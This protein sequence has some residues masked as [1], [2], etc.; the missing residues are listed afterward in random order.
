MLDSI[1]SVARRHGLS[2]EGVAALEVAWFAALEAAREENGSTLTAGTG[3]WAL[4]S[5]SV[6][7]PSAPTSVAATQPSTAPGMRSALPARYADL[8]VL[9]RGGMGEVRRVRDLELN[10]TLAMKIAHA[11]F[12][13][14]PAALSRF[15][16]EAQATAQLQHP[17]IVPVHDLGRLP[18]GRFWF[19]MKEVRG[20][21]LTEA[22][23]DVHAVSRQG[24][25][26]APSGW[27][28]RRLVTAFHA[29]CHAVAYA[30]ARG[31]VH[32]D[33]KPDNVMLGVY[34][35]V[36][37]LDWGIAKLLGRPARPSDVEPALE[38]GDEAIETGRGARAETRV[39]QV[40]GTPA[41]MPPEQARGEVDRIDAR[42]DVYALG[43]ILYELLSGRPPYEGTPRAVLAQVLAGP[44]S[45]VGRAAPT[46]SLGLFEDLVDV[47][48]ASGPLLPEDLTSAC[49]RA[50]ARDPAERHATADALAHAV[51]DWLDG[52]R[53]RE[54]AL[55]VV[56]AACAKVPER[57]ALL[58][59]AMTLRGEA[60]ALLE[61]IEPWRPEDD[62]APG[63]VKED[64]AAELDR[65]AAQLDLD[66][67]HLLNAALTHAPEL[68]EAH[69]ALAQRYRAAHAAAEHARA[70]AQL[71]EVRLRRH[72]AS[73]PEAHPDR[74]GH[75]AY[76]Q[77]DGVLTLVTDPPGAE[78]R[79]FR[80]TLYHRRLVPTFERV[81]GVTPLRGVTLPMGSYL[82][83]VH[84]PERVAVRYPVVMGR[85]T[86]W[87]GVP[88]GGEAPLP[89]VLPLPSELGPDDVYIP[90]GWFWSG[91]EGQA[92][93]ALPRRRV[94]EDAFVMRRFPVTNREYLRFLDD[95]VAKGR[96]T[97]AL[98][99]APR[100]RPGSVGMDGA[101]IYG[102][103]GGRFFIQPDA[104]GD[105]WHPDD[106]VMMVAWSGAEAFAAWEA[107]RSGRPWC[108][109]REQAWE[110]AARGVDGRLY[111]WGDAFDPSW[112][113]TRVS[114]QGRMLPA[115]VD[116]FPVD[117]SV[118]GVR[119]CAGNVR[120]W[121]ADTNGREGTYRVNRGGSWYN[122]PQYARLVS[123]FSDDPHFRT[124]NLGFRLARALS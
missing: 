14:S 3:T 98:Q 6:S 15:L 40:A 31:V 106:P 66:E 38:G 113:C 42:S 37:V 79:L 68:P 32:R 72:V 100:E 35:E 25:E 17:H 103:E 22:I 74:A 60:A 61:R 64:A 80:H 28:L 47:S 81:L 89:I 45:P 77:G 52:A 87:D 43:A 97:E 86:H 49:A 118:Y 119:G 53:R 63:W 75:L 56:E 2:D 110:K 96:E 107:S 122:D 83:E 8:G 55:A 94:W 18:D 95:L 59:R 30:H 1:V 33:L 27:S 76:L 26:T 44:P 112:A 54:Q 78:V 101:L 108:L 120:D 23:A 99:H 88:P 71:P 7:P 41:Y 91:G 84:H 34:G 116:S 12:V 123:R 58:A 67:E 5:G 109:P 48:G 85:G 82:L 24:W 69:A 19:T 20:R 92:P 70:D 121:T 65:Q 21:T 73:L 46:I 51:G 90:A 13:H 111:P 16:E 39:G 10:R 104:D 102:F 62:K 115:V 57:A 93:G 124:G 9:G 4:E 105:V 11:P 36:Y 114:H 29:V 50:M 117:A